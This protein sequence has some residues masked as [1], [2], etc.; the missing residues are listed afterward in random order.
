[1]PVGS[2]ERGLA[3]ENGDSILFCSVGEGV[4]F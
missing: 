2:L 3:V 1:M 4:L